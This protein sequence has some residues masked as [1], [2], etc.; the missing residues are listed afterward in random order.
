MSKVLLKEF[1]SF[2][3]DGVCND[4]LTESE[5]QLRKS[6]AIILSGVCQKADVVNANNRI[7]GKKILQKA[8]E[9]YQ[10]KIKENRALGA[11]D[12]PD[13]ETVLYK[14]AS[15]MF[16]RLWMENDGTVY[17]TCKVLTTPQGRILEALINDN[18]GLGI[19]SRGIGSVREQSGVTIV[20]EDFMLCAIDFVTE[21]S[22]PGAEMFVVNESVEKKMFTKKDRLWRILNDITGYK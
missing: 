15:H 5:R 8:V 20:E 17:G 13:T 2:C 16:L 19:S 18:V 11:L 21:N 6:G 7:Y 9:D 22:A 4:I 14:D 1:T 3:K 10:R 12:H